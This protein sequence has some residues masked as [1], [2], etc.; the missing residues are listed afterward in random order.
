MIF[1]FSLFTAPDIISM[2]RVKRKESALKQLLHDSQLLPTRRLLGPGK[3]VYAM[4]TG[5]W[6]SCLFPS[7]GAVYT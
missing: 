5:E 2:M 7:F 6:G 3:Q 1:Q 4:D